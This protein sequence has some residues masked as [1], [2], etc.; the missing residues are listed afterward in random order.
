MCQIIGSKILFSIHMMD[1]HWIKILNKRTYLLHNGSTINTNIITSKIID[2][3]PKLSLSTS[4]FLKP[5]SVA[6]CRPYKMHQSSAVR[7]EHFPTLTTNPYLHTSRSSRNNPLPKVRPEPPSRETS[8][9]SFNVSLDG[10]HQLTKIG[11][12]EIPA[13]LSSPI[14]KYLQLYT[15]SLHHPFDHIN[16]LH[17]NNFRSSPNFFENKVTSLFPNVPTSYSK[18]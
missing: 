1:D 18:N 10:G 5:K 9:L 14:K 11:D 4:N 15:C 3:P 2:T 7:I 6:S 17:H 13:A 12:Q 8:V 16:D